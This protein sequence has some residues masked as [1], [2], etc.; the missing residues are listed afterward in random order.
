[1]YIEEAE[2]VLKESI[3]N[4]I[5]VLKG[6]VAG[7]KNLA[8]IIAFEI[9]RSAQEG[10]AS[11]ID[12]NGFSFAPLKVRNGVPLNDTGQLRA[13]MQ[14][15]ITGQ[16]I[17]EIALAGARNNMIGAVHQHGATIRPVRAKL[18]SFPLPGGGRAFA[19][20]VV[21]PARQFFPTSSSY[22]AQDAFKKGVEK[23]KV[24]LGNLKFE[25]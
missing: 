22:R 9:R 17:A 4:V 11:G 24:E 23:V 8:G 15:S 25:L 5:K 10:M 2:V 12:I 1:M 6:D 7:D 20:Q 14:V 18:L 21:I 3:E 16:N 13:S 19:K